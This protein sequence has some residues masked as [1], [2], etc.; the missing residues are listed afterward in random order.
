MTRTFEELESARRQ[1]AALKRALKKELRKE[2][3]DGN[4]DDDGPAD[5]LSLLSDIPR[6]GIKKFND[7][8]VC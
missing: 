2:K 1:I 6:Q 7:F 3:R 5:K 8:I 4:D